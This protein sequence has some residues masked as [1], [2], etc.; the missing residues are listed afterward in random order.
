QTIASSLSERRIKGSR[1]ERRVEVICEIR[2]GQDFPAETVVDGQAAVHAEVVSSIEAH[3]LP[4]N[5]VGEDR[6]G[7]VH[8]DGHILEFHVGNVIASLVAPVALIPDGTE[9]AA[10]L[11]IG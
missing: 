1:V 4:A 5:V 3:V 6:A 11:K 10:K 2:I 9:D 8:T 7:F